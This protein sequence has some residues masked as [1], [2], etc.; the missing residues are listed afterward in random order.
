VT[1]APSQILWLAVSVMTAVALGIALVTVTPAAW[2]GTVALGVVCITALL[3]A[4]VAATRLSGDA[5]SLLN[6]TAVFYLVTF[7]VGGLYYA[8]AEPRIR[9]SFFDRSNVDEAILIGLTSW[10][11]LAAGYVVNPLH[12]TQRLIPVLRPLTTTSPIPV[13][14]ILLAFGWL[15]RLETIE[16]GRYFHVPASGEIVSTGSS[17][18]ISAAATLPTLA[19]AFVGARSYLDCPSRRIR[20]TYYL[21]LVVEILWAIPTGSRANVLTLFVMVAVI[22][23]YGR[24]RRF[25]VAQVLGTALAGVFIVLPFGA[26]Y[27]GDNRHF[28]S[29]P[30]ESLEA[31]AATLTSRSPSAIVDAG[32]ESTVSRFSGVASVA[33]IVGESRRLD[34]HAPGETYLWIAEAAVPRAVH[35]EKADPGLFGNEFGRAYGILAPSD[36]ITGIT[37]TQPGELYLNFGLLGILLGMPLIGAVYRTVDVLFRQ[38][39]HPA[40]LAV[41][42]IVVWNFLNGSE[43]ILAVGVV[44]VLKLAAFCALALFGASRVVEM[45]GIASVRPLPPPSPET[46]RV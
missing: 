18:M 1:N 31:A 21:L 11:L 40:V 41:F 33:A 15:A 34:S 37:V 22:R 7:G 46:R 9:A 42:A 10:G 20:I 38:R 30:R 19:T 39:S 12:N 4:I 28:Q 35:P 44:G 29:H 3:A 23:Y 17:W 27:R 32:L 6:V 24:S 25:P 16:A 26:E 13:A 36:R 8:F 45:L 5:F 43:S 2:F 14:A